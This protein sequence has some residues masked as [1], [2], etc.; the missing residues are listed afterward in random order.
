MQAA[1]LFGQHGD[2]RVVAHAACRFGGIFHHRVQDGFEFFER[3]ADGQLAAAQ[4]F[5][6]V[7]YGFRCVG[8]N[9]VVDLLD[10]G[11]PVAISLAA[12]EQ[13]E[14]FRVLVETR[15]VEIH[16]DGFARADAAL[17]DNIAFFQRHHAGF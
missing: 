15:R 7:A 16:G 12:G 13:I 17:L 9:D 8:F 5:A 14:K 6:G 3:H 2:G 11:G 4:S 1:I 10:V